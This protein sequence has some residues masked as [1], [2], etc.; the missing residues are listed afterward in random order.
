MLK[1]AVLPLVLLLLSLLVVVLAW[2]N[3]QLRQ[4]NASLA[5]QMQQARSAAHGPALGS[6]PLPQVLHSTRQSRVDIGGPRATAQVLY[7]FSTACRYCLASMPQLQQIASARGHSELVGVGLPPYQ[8][9]PAYAD[10]HAL[11]FP[12]AIDGKGDVA[13]Q[14]GIRVTPMLMVLAADGS[15]AYK[16]AGQLDAQT[17]Q[18][19]LATLNPGST[20]Q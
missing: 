3:R 10:T 4:I 11:R 18:A 20:T 14:Y 16:H 13:R 9:L 8:E 12:V 2:Q 17:V 15:V 5:D 7:F 19:V 1:R 6:V